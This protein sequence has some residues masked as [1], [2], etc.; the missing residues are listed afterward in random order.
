[1]AW[2]ISSLF[3]SSTS[4]M[5]AKPKPLSSVTIR[6]LWQVRKENFTLQKSV[7]H[8]C[9]NLAFTLY[10]QIR[11]Q[12]AS[13][14]ILNRRHNFLHILLAE[15]L[16]ISSFGRSGCVTHALHMLTNECACALHWIITWRALHGTDQRMYR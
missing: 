15:G 13:R 7:L 9:S 16:L 3:P 8:L 11:C 12:K 6:V 2:L 5:D 1:M 4:S 10:L 14:I